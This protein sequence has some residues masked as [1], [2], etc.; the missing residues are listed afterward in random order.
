MPHMKAKVHLP[1]QHPM[2]SSFLSPVIHVV[3]KLWVKLLQLDLQTPPPTPSH[4]TPPLRPPPPAPKT[5]PVNR[6]AGWQPRWRL[7]L[8]WPGG[9]E[10]SPCAR[11]GPERIKGHYFIQM[12]GSLTGKRGPMH[13]GVREQETQN[14]LLGTIRVRENVFVDVS[15]VGLC[16][17]KPFRAPVTEGSLKLIGV[18]GAFWMD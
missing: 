5:P 8:L 18:R 13:I 11:R 12:A 6:L 3:K 1:L 15:V 16:S 9:T 7:W 4:H 10:C 2:V 17:N 14:G